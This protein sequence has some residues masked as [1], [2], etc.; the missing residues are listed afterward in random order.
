MLSYDQK[1]ILKMI[2]FN[3]KIMTDVKSSKRKTEM[4]WLRHIIACL[5]DSCRDSLW[6]E[7]VALQYTYKT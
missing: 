2:F 3:D 1:Y 6:I 4:R 7:D 5:W